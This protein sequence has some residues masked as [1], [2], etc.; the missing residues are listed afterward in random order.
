[1]IVF[2]RML[3]KIFYFNSILFQLSVELTIIYIH[4][5]VKFV[6]HLLWVKMIYYFFRRE[7]FKHKNLYN[8]EKKTFWNILIS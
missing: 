2:L 1:M 3:K 6:K 5:V 8:K 4:F 7:F